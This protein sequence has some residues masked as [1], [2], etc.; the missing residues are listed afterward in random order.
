MSVMT[1]DEDTLDRLF[2]NTPL[3]QDSLIMLLGNYEFAELETTNG[4][5]QLRQQAQAKISDLIHSSKVESVL[6]TGF[7][8]Q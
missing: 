8:I 2:D 7:V 4:K 3:I 5:E 1:R 6:F